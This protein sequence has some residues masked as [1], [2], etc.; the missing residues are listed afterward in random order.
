[1]RINERAVEWVRSLAVMIIRH[2]SSVAVGIEPNVF[3]TTL[4]MGLN[5]NSMSSSRGIPEK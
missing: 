3:G 1:M 5:D 2:V 4:V